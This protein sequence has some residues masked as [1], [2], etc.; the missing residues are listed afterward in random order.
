M[1]IVRIGLVGAGRWAGN[2]IRTIAAMPEAKIVRIARA[3]DTR[4][5]LP[6]TDAEI[7]TDFR[8][9][10]AATDLDAV[11][12]ATPPGLHAEQTLSAVAEG[13]LPVL[14]EKPLVMKREEGLAI[15]EAAKANE[16]F[17]MIEH[18]HLFH[19]PFRELKRICRE[20]GPV[21]AITTMAGSWGSFRKDAPVL[22]DWGSHDV[23]MCIDLLGEK[24]ERFSAKRIERRA[25]PDGNGDTVALELSFRGGT[26][27]NISISN[28]REKKCRSFTTRLAGFSL[29]YDDLAADKLVRE[30]AGGR[31][32]LPFVSTPPLTV[33]VSEFLTA[34]RANSR[35]L[36]SL[37]LGMDVTDTLARCEECLNDG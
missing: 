1:S 9:V 21:Q 10:T 12:I 11:I 29:T 25:T 36:S 24:P 20:R 14:V 18:T 31:E 4:D 6:P 32:V 8:R 26:V 7:T 35:D 30:S 33:A 22:W 16:G 23:A 5:G 17:V 28:L 13:K 34:V 37:R 3:R 27:A 15:Y 2:Y 19:G